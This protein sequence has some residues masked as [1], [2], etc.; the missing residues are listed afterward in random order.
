MLG[1]ICIEDMVSEN[2]SLK[3]VQRYNPMI[4]FGLGSPIVADTFW[5]DLS[6]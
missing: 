5:F 4:Q 2:F 1:I 3:P 6:P